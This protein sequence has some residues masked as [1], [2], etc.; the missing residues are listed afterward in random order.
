MPAS[1]HSSSVAVEGVPL[2]RLA[3]GFAGENGNVLRVQA[4]PVMFC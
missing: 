4:V 3:G 2:P 1:L